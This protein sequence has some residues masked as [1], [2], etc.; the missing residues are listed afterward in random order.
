MEIPIR[1]VSE[2]ID[3]LTG[4]MEENWLNRNLDQFNFQ[5]QIYKIVEKYTTICLLRIDVKM[6]LISVKD[7]KD[8]YY[9][10]Y[11]QL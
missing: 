10:K 7:I 5:L 3:F 1:G 4:I 11:M 9:A 6:L 8:L 2:L